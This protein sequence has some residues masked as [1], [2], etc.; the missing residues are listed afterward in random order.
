[1]KSQILFRSDAHTYTSGK[2]INYTSVSTLVGKFKKPYNTEYWSTYKAYEKLLG[3]DEFKSLKKLAGFP[4]EDDRLF[5]F[6][7]S[8][9]GDASIGKVVLEILGE[10]KDKKDKSIIK[11]NDYH[12]FKENQA[13]VSGV[14]L[15]PYNNKEFKTVE[16]THITV[17]GSVEYRE[18]IFESLKDLEDGFHPELILWNND[19]K[20]AGQADKVYIETIDGIRYAEIDDYKTNRKIDVTS[21]FGNMLP[22]LSHLKDCNYNHYRLQ[23]STYA[24]MLEQEGFTVRNTG[25]THLNKPYVFPYMKKEVELM[26][27]ITDFDKI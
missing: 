27:G 23:I 2:K 11:G 13:K 26:L 10:W 24:W 6:L 4:L 8:H 21:F 25:F 7:S 16:S 9:I 20:L 22:P 17:K 1:M 19:Y 3:K 18:P 12:A 14:C 15:N 5:D